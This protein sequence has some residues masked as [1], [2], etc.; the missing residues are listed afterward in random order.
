[1]AKEKKN[2]EW[3]VAKLK[4]YRA[5]RLRIYEKDESGTV[6]VSRVKKYPQLAYKTPSKDNGFTIIQKAELAHIDF[7]EHN[8]YLNVYD[9]LKPFFKFKFRKPRKDSKKGFTPAQ[10]ARLTV[11]WDK[12]APTIKGVEKGRY[13]AIPVKYKS[14]KKKGKRKVSKK[15]QGEFKHNND[16]IFVGEGGATVIKRKRAVLD[17][18]YIETGDF[19]EYETVVADVSRERPGAERRSILIPLPPYVFNDVKGIP[20]FMKYLA[21]KYPGNAFSMS[22]K[23]KM[24]EQLFTLDEWGYFENSMDKFGKLE[25]EKEGRKTHVVNGVWGYYYGEEEVQNFFDYDHKEA[26]AYILERIASD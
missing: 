1:M 24:T 20:Y 17:E 10:K 19:E 7:T 2:F 8:H 5:K 13:T 12:W 18:D 14:G 23:G 15:F 6:K 25:W 21:E 11:L 16:F 4:E 22:V 9:R 3:Y 26:Y